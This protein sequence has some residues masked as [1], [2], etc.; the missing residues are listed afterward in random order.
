MIVSHNTYVSCKNIQCI[1]VSEIYALIDA[2]FK[3]IG[4]TD[5]SSNWSLSGASY[6]QS[7]DEITLTNST[8]GNTFSIPK[9]NGSSSG[10]ISSDTNVCFE[11]D[12]KNVNCTD[13][14]FVIDGCSTSIHNYISTTEF[15]TVKIYTTDDKYYLEV[16]GSPINNWNRGTRSGVVSIRLPSSQGFKFKNLRL[17]VL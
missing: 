13:L 2:I 17:Y 1:F 14:R 6:N 5:N 12:V 10:Y 11:L 7:D 9:V 15:K 3:D 16:D 8:S 4:D